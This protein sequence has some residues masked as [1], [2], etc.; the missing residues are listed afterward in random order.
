MEAVHSLPECESCSAVYRVNVCGNWSRVMG[1][2]GELVRQLQILDLGTGIITAISFISLF[3]YYCM[4]L[5][6]RILGFGGW[7]CLTFHLI[8]L[9]M[10]LLMSLTLDFV[11]LFEASFIVI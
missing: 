2:A 10:F 7:G 1:L 11:R 5:R 3:L 8:E 4:V 9:S 6:K